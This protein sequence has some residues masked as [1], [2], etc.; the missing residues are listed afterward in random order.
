ML[1]SDVSPV[2]CSHMRLHGRETGHGPKPSHPV[3]GEPMTEHSEFHICPHCG[4]GDIPI[5]IVK[6]AEHADAGFRMAL[7]RMPR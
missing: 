6:R 2:C 4:F 5:L 1:Q 7:S 3:G